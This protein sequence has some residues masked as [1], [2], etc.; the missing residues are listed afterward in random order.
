MSA[1]WCTLRNSDERGVDVVSC[2]AAHCTPLYA[3]DAAIAAKS[4]GFDR[5]ALLAIRAAL[6]P[7]VARLKNGSGSGEHRLG[8]IPPPPS[9]ETK[10]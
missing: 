9:E 4:P 3:L 1:C 8:T 10:P 6:A 5:D 7:L 2:G